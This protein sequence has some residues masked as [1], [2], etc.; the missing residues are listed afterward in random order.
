MNRR[1]LLLVPALAWLAASALPAAGSY[2]VVVS[3]ATHADAQWRGVVDAL[4]KKHDGT[5][6]AY[7]ASV[8]ESLAALKKQFPRHVCFV[9]RPEEAGRAFVAQV[10]R[11][12]RRLDDDPYTDALWGILTGYDAAAALRI[13]ETAEPLVVRRVSSGTVVALSHCTVGVWFCELV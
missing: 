12:T 1:Q 8:D 6:V 10:H 7:D 4:L 13:A 3:K 2:A 5:L 9:A 11:L